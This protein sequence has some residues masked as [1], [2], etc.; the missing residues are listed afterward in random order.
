MLGLSGVF[1]L[2]IGA[3][4]LAWR[5]RLPAI[6]LLL[7]AGFA[8]GPLTGQRLVDPDAL[9]G[10]GLHPFVSLAV[11]VILFEGGLSLRFDELRGVGRAVAGL[12]VLGPVVSLVLTTVF[13]HTVL[14]FA[15]ESSALLGAILI[16]TGPT[17]V[18]PLLRHVRPTASVSRV[19][20]WEG[21]VTDPIGAVLAVLVFQ[22]FIR[23]DAERGLAVAGLVRATL[24]GVGAGGAVA[25]LT[26]VLLRRKAIPDFLEGPAVLALAVASFVIA[27]HV[28]EESGLLAITLMGIGIGNQRRVVV[29][30]IVQFE[31]NVRLI[32]VSVLFIL[33]AARLPAEEFSRLDLAS[34]GFV[35]LL[36]LVVRPASVLL[37]TTRSGL[38]IAERAFLAWMAPRGIV[39]ASVAS[40]FALELDPERFPEA[41][42]HLMPVVFLVICA[43]VLVYGLT[44]APVASRLGVAKGTPQGVLFLGAHR[45]AREIARA[46]TEGGIEVLLVDRN[47]SDV[48]AARIEGL[49]AHFGNALVDDFEFR[50]PLDGIGNLVCLTY[51]DEVNALACLQFATVFGR[52]RVYQLPPEPES[53]DGEELPPHLRGHLLFGEE[54]TYWALD[55]RFRSGAL[56]KRTRLGEEFS[57]EDFVA[58]HAAPDRPVLPLFRIDGEGRLTVWSP[59]TPPKPEAGDTLIAVVG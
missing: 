14:S 48:Q 3:Q 25:F 7:A 38:G 43:T 21:I 16:V 47:H 15:W 41:S 17:V 36:L 30:H 24:A 26:V 39:A 51:N 54:V 11:A 32:L 57:F 45:W 27:N 44:A 5:L 23:E 13:A 9:L 52:D 34:G 6:L 35:V 49:R 8:V 55:A 33:L 59:D 20:R 50:V 29:E 12:L 1:L 58:E 31:E 18:G 4:W 53:S 56:V 40:V 46:L 22:A 28:Q 2:G 19:L 10:D 37:A 42:A